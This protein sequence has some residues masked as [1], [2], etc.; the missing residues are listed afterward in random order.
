MTENMKSQ[1][2]YQRYIPWSGPA[3]KVSEKFR[4]NGKNLVKY[5]PEMNWTKPPAKSPTETA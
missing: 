2:R 1:K 5:G 4:L 3:K